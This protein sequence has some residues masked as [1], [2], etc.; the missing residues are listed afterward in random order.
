MIG[1]L[2]PQTRMIA[3]RRRREREF[4]L[5]CPGVALSEGL[6]KVSSATECWRRASTHPDWQAVFRHPATAA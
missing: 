3:P 2:L 1:Q 5:A 4:G 6:F